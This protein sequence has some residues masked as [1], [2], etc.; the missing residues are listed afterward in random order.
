VAQRHWKVS[1]M[2][3]RLANRS[4]ALTIMAPRFA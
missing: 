3:A 1:C 2:T 4:E